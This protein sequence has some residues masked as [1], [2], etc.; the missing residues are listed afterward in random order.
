MK[1][2][3][4]AQRKHSPDD[5]PHSY[6][7][8]GRVGMSIRNGKRNYTRDRATV[9]CDICKST[10]AFRA[11]PC[12]ECRGRGCY[13]FNKAPGIGWHKCSACN[14]TGRRAHKVNS[15]SGVSDAQRSKS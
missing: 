2:H 5:E 12:A 10:D 15:G 13:R 4:I 11:E 9:T 7:A 8:C 14:G 3:Y 6:I 1:I